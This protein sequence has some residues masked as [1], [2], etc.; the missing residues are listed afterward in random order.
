METVDLNEMFIPLIGRLFDTNKRID[1]I[2][3]RK[4][5]EHKRKAWIKTVYIITLQAIEKLHIKLNYFILSLSTTQVSADIFLL[6]TTVNVLCCFSL[7]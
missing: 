3:F 2:T 4:F 5:T 7:I 6:C 1:G